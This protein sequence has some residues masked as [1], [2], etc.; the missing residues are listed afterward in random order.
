M[1]PLDPMIQAQLL[2]QLGMGGYGG[3]EDDMY[4][5][6]DPRMLYWLENAYDNGLMDGRVMGFEQA[7]QLYYYLQQLQVARRMQMMPYHGHGQFVRRPRR[8]DA[9]ARQRLMLN[10]GM[11]GMI[12]GGVGAYAGFGGGR[13]LMASPYGMDGMRGGQLALMASPWGGAC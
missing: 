9:L 12:G 11:R 3:F 6:M 1:M 8:R 2:G 4:D 13:A 10:G 5:M 7:S